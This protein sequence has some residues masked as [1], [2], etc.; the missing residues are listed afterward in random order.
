[1]DAVKRFIRN[2]IVLCV[3][4]VLA[5]ISAFVIHPDKSY[6]AYIDYRTLSILLAL[7]ITMAGL[8]RLHVLDR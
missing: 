6:F 2:E 7:M 8:Q 1:M 4:F 5:V 3:A